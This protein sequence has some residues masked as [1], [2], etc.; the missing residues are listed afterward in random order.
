[1]FHSLLLYSN[2]YISSIELPED[3]YAFS[4]NPKFSKDMRENG[5]KLIDQTS[6]FGRMGIPNRY[7]TITDANRNYEVIL[8][9]FS[10]GSLN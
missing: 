8:L 1:M 3:L 4:Y 5:W 2:A 9:L 10:F 7:W 6:D